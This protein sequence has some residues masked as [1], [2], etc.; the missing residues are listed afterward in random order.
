MAALGCLALITPLAEA[1]NTEVAAT[2]DGLNPMQPFSSG[3]TA[4]MSTSYPNGMIHSDML[5]S[6]LSEYYENIVDQVVVT[7]IEDITS[8]APY[9]YMSIYHIS[10]MKRG[11]DR[12]PVRLFVHAL[13][14]HL[15]LMRANLLASIHP[16]VESN[17]PAIFS[18]LPSTL[19]ANELTEDILALNRHI[20]FQLGLIVNVNEAAD[21]MIA[22][23]MPRLNSENSNDNEED[24]D[25]AYY[26]DEQR[27]RVS[28][29]VRWQQK[30]RQMLMTLR[31]HLVPSE[32][33][34][35]EEM[36]LVDASQQEEESKESK[37][38]A[39]W[40]RAW[41]AEIEQIL[42]IEFDQRVQDATLSILED[43]LVDDDN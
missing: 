38:L 3:Q 1:A 26:D 28:V 5:T 18:P 21:I 7:L 17:L 19:A 24:D 40:L 31:R 8:S 2:S 36:V 15:N 41:L 4:T 11:A 13:R 34:Q 37:A 9:S 29:K 42:V 39:D 25:D 43:F 30:S 12:A 6:A 33:E 35:V 32:D 20:G 16:L 22:Q 14:D 23:S 27:H 10:P